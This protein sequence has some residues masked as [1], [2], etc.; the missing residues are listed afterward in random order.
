MRL[1]DYIGTASF[2]I[3]GCLTASSV[4]MDILGCTIV[5][6]ITA[7]PPNGA[8]RTGPN[9]NA[10]PC[11]LAAALSVTSYL[12]RVISNRSLVGA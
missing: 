4:G 2:A 5:G 3:T 9:V 12:E 6:T 8:G 11:R 1:S 7:V 10:L